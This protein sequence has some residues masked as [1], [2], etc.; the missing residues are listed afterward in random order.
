VPDNLTIK[1]KEILGSWNE[2]GLTK[3]GDLEAYLCSVCDNFYGI[4]CP[5]CGTKSARSH[6]SDYETMFHVQRPIIP[7]WE[8]GNSWV[9]II[10]HKCDYRFKVIYKT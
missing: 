10:C 6:E 7:E 8:M 2:R 3:Y 4:A 9:K 1:E 5:K